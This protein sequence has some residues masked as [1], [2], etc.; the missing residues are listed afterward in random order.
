MSAR[1]KSLPK[2]R[3]KGSRAKGLTY[4][5]KIGR[6]LKR[7]FSH[8]DVHSDVWF[9]CVDGNGQFYACVDH[10]VL[11]PSAGFV[12]ECKLTQSYLAYDQLFFK[13]MPIIEAHYGLPVFGI[14]ACRHLRGDD[15]AC[16]EISLADLIA[17]PKPGRWL[18]HNLG[19]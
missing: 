7:D 11:T 6:M 18:W 13:Y 12:V 9:D 3:L 15:D 19:V 17:K 4:E 16:E 14:Q 1:P 2:P 5:R 10:F 8:L